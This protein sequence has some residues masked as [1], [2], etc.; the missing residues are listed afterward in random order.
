[1]NP[2]AIRCKL[3]CTG[4]TPADGGDGSNGAYVSFT[5]QYDSTIPEDRRF[6]V[7]TPTGEARFLINNPVALSFFDVGANYYFDAV[8]CEP[9]AEPPHPTADPVGGEG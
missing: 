5:T 7:A 1:M 4:K 8:R 9:P 2:T 6:T 3:M